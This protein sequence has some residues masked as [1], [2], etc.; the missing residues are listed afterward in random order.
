MLKN[1]RDAMIQKL[2]CNDLKKKI[3]ETN[4]GFIETL[5]EQITEA[6]VS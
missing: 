6:V 3:T 1:Q 5:I 2:E 4:F